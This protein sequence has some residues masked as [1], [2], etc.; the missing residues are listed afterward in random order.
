[1]ILLKNQQN[2]D[3]KF[4][5]DLMIIDFFLICTFPEWKIRTNVPLQ[6][7]LYFNF[8][9]IVFW[10]AVQ[11]WQWPMSNDNLINVNVLT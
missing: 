4:A 8:Y 11:V 1:M 7:C 3:G 6:I 9:L 5:P 10:I 2:L